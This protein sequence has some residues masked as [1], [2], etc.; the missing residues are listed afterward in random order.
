MSDA[1]PDV[2]P[3]LLEK[4][5]AEEKSKRRDLAIA[6]EEAERTEA[7]WKRLREAQRDGHSAAVVNIFRKESGLFAQLRQSK[8]EAIPLLEALYRESEERAAGT[9]RRFAALFPKACDAAGIE[10]DPT[11]RHPRYSIRGFIQTLIDERNLEAEITPRDANGVTIS[12]DIDPLVAHLQT[13][14]RRLFETKRDPRRFLTGLRKAYQ[15]VLREEK[16][17]LWR[18]AS[19]S[20]CG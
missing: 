11:S 20:P 12:L 3:Q 18:G 2:L 16:K 8:D 4:R 6:L 14:V 15:A 9:T 10:I 19:A 7:V 13:E 17:S 1:S 5:V